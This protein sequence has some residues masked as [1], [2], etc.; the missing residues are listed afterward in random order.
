MP[1]FAKK[2][3]GRFVYG[4]RLYREGMKALVLD[5]DGSAQLFDLAKD[6][7][8]LN[9]LDEPTE[10]WVKRAATAFPEAAS[11]PGLVVPAEALQQLKALGYME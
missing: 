8:M 11:G 5:D 4:S 3:G 2:V 9:P 1:V 6:R 7:A 10:P